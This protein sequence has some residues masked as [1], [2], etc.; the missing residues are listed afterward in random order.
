M[1]TQAKS[2]IDWISLG[3][4][5]LVVLLSVGAIGMGLW[6]Q[7]ELKSVDRHWY[8]DRPGFEEALAEHNKTGK[9]MVLYFHAPWCQYCKAFNEQVLNTDKMV[10]FLGKNYIKAKVYPD[11]TPERALMEQFET[12]GFPTFFVKYK[13]SDKFYRVERH[14]NQ[15]PI[16]VDEFIQR[17]KDAEKIGTGAI[18]PQLDKAPAMPAGESNGPPELPSGEH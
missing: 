11:K 14:E 6:K 17:V 15:Q 7:V 3:I 2:T 8:E 1:T 10:L 9:P 4:I 16:T 13:G 5:G 12:T 18:V